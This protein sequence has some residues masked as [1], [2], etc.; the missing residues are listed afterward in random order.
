VRNSTIVA[1]LASLLVA[2]TGTLGE[3]GGDDEPPPPP[4]A[5]DVQII[6]RDGT[7]PQ[8]NVRVL[9]QNTDDS[10]LAEA[11]TGADGIAIAEMPDGGNLTVIRTYP[12]AVPPAESRS[13]E[14]YT[15]LG[16][17]AG[18][19]L[20]LG[21]AITDTTPP[22]AINVTVPTGAVGT[23]KIVTPCGS[24]QGTGPLVP[25]TVRG[26]DTMVDFY[27]TDQ[28][29]SAFT[30][31]VAYG[32]NIDLSLEPLLGALA[33]TLSATN[34]LPTTTSVNVDLRIVAGTYQLYSTGNKR[35]DQTSTTVNLPNLTGVDQLAVATITGA[36]GTQMVGKREAYSA[37]PVI[38]DASAGLIPY[39]KT[40]DYSPLGISWTEQ[41]AG[42]A[43][44]VVATVNVTRTAVGGEYLR[45]II[46]PHTGLTMRMPILT[47]ADAMYNPTPA[48]QLAGSLGLVQVTGGYDAVRATAFTVSNLLQLTPAMGTA[49]LS[50]T[51]AVPSLD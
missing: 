35:V 49:T 45:A 9:F 37:S 13:P 25:I 28:D 11:V 33:A 27:V 34:V 24:G 51:G 2:C 14:I 48:D 32:E 1:F 19:R 10:I 46:A 40:P 43:D 3:G 26:C 38:V 31:R 22:S 17:K 4:P 47:G 5:T 44:V 39:V 41:G 6:V 30:K 42:T 7:A 15:Y 12:P 21:R 18:D 8:A 36:E 16:V 29:Q 20:Q 50:Y 23:V